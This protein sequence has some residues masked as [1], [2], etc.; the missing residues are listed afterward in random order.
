MSPERHFSFRTASSNG[1]LKIRKRLIFSLF[2]IYEKDRPVQNLT[3]QKWMM[4]PI[5]YLLYSLKQVGFY[6]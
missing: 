2:V 5:P 3:L 6:N 1:F 4:F